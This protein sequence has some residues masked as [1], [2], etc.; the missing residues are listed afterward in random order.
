MGNR[1][2]SSSSERSLSRVSRAPQASATPAAPSTGRNVSHRM[3]AVG[4]SRQRLDHQ[5][6]GCQRQRREPTSHDSPP[7]LRDD[8]DVTPSTRSGQAPSL[9]RASGPQRHRAEVRVLE[10]QPTPPTT[11]IRPSPPCSH[12]PV[13]ARR[14]GRRVWATP[15]RATSPPRGRRWLE[16]TRR[17]RLSCPSWE[18]IR[19]YASHATR[20]PIGSVARERTGTPSG[21]MAA[22]SSPS[23]IAHQDPVVTL[24]ALKR[25]AACCEQR[26]NRLGI[27]SAVDR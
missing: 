17:R 24:A 15:P 3:V 19:V 26:D 10:G 25:D 12:R 2:R 27:R 11:R 7:I 5:G 13:M 4:R 22:T 23:T 16:R 21:C 20:G 14:P 8:L 9:R 1:A 6:R 18:E